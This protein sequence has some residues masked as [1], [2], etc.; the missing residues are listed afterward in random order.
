MEIA[1]TY[2]NTKFKVIIFRRGTSRTAHSWKFGNNEIET[3]SNIAYLGLI[4]SNK[5]RFTQA[6]CKLADQANKSLCMTIIQAH[7]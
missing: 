5:G 3:V 1:L 2:L 4:F 6:Q 7:Q